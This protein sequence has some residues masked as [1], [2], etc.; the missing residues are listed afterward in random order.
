MPSEPRLCSTILL[1]WRLPLL[2]WSLWSLKK[3]DKRRPPEPDV[4]EEAIVAAED[5]ETEEGDE[6]V[7]VA[8]VPSVHNGGRPSLPEDA[9]DILGGLY[10]VVI[11]PDSTEIKLYTV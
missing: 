10:T 4:G 11:E 6:V 5:D 1:P 8:S 3:E 9:A 2:S 7:S